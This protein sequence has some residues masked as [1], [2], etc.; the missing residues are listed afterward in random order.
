MIFF[1]D[2]CGAPVVLWQMWNTLHAFILFEVYVIRSTILCIGNTRLSSLMEHLVV[3]ELKF[4]QY[5]YV[6]LSEVHLEV[7]DERNC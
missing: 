4:D 7:H 1:I 2:D 3:L 5:G 6:R